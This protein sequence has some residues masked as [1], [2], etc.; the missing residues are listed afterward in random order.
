M[1]DGSALD[2]REEREDEGHTSSLRRI[3]DGRAR[4]LHRKPGRVATAIGASTPPEPPPRVRERKGGREVRRPL[5]KGAAGGGTATEPCTDAG[6]G[7]RETLSCVVRERET[8]S[9]R[10]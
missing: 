8:C 4:G 5:S 3:Y 10:E 6:R 2:L 1:R 9:L 7:E